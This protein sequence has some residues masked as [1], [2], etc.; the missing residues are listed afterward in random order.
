MFRLHR[1]QSRGDVVAGRFP[2]WRFAARDFAGPSDGNHN[3][4]DSLAVDDN[5]EATATATSSPKKS[6]PVYLW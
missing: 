4:Q 3:M 1:L 6:S 2:D 5:L